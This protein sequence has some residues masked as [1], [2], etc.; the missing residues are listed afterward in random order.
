MYVYEF[1]DI[2]FFIKSLKQP[3]DKFNIPDHVAFITGTIRSA[4]IK[5]YPKTASTNYI[6]NTYF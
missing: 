4:G 3:S 5:L 1:A 2:I 6:M